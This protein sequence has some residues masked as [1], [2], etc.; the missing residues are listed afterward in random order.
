[1][2][3]EE[4]QA[5]AVPPVAH[6]RA[7][8][9]ADARLAELQQQGHTRQ[10]HGHW[11]QPRERLRPPPEPRALSQQLLRKLF[12]PSLSLSNVTLIIATTKHVSVLQS[13]IEWRGE[14]S[15]H[16]GRGEQAAGERPLRLQSHTAED[17]QAREGVAV[18]SRGAAE[19][20]EDPHRLVHV[21]RQGR[22]V[23][24]QGKRV[25][26]RVLL[27]LLQ[28]HH[29]ECARCRELAQEAPRALRRNQPDLCRGITT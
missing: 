5:R 12:S 18:L 25:E 29:G 3:A 15:A 26:G 28:Q 4:A 16:S 11:P 8:L 19:S 9:H 1:M 6:I 14:H 17:G 24:E 2:A 7:G 13:N 27:L 23:P 22:P 10:L 21:P 20:T